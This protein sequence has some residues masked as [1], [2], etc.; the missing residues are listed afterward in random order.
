MQASLDLAATGYAVVLADTAPAIGG[1]MSRLDKTFP[2]NDCAMCIMS[3]K[4]V[5]TGR[6]LDIDIVPGAD[7][8]SLEG[9]PGRFKAALKVRARYVDLEKCTACGDC[10]AACPVELP[11]PFD[12]GLGPRRAAY[13][14]YPQAVPNAYAIDK[15]GTSPCRLAC[16]SGVNVQG[17]VALTR[18]GK[19]R[20][21]WELV[22]EAL[23]FPI[24][25]GTV[26]HRPCER[27][28]QR[29]ELDEPL[30]VARIKRFLGQ[31]MLEHPDVENEALAK[32][33]VLPADEPAQVAIVGSGPA[34]L[35][36]AYHLARA[37]IKAVVFEAL[38]VP[39]GMMRVGI[40]SYRLPRDLL[41]HEIELI[42]QLGVEIHCNQALGRDFTLA[43]LFKQGFRAV[44]LAVGAHIPQ[45][46]D[47]PGEDLPGVFHGVEFL[48]GV[49]LDDPPVLGE[50]VLVVGGGNTAVDTAR[51][52]IRLGARNVRLLYRRTAGEMT[53]Q[54]EE[55]DEA[56][57]EGVEIHF[58]VSPVEV[59]AGPDGRAAGL[60]CI[61]N[62]LGEPDAS[63]RRRPVPI[64]GSEFD[65]SASSVVF[66]TSQRPGTAGFGNEGI[67]LKLGRGG[68]IAADPLTLATSREGVFAAGDA[69]TGPA[70]L[71]DAAGAGRRAAESI[72][73]WLLGED[74]AAGRTLVQQPEDIP[75]LPVELAGRP[76][77]RRPRE[78]KL[79]PETRR[80]TFAEVLK[81]LDA[82]AA[83][84]EA[85][86]CL[87]CGGCSECLQCVAACLPKCIDHSQQDE[88]RTVE[89]GAV[90]LAAGAVPANAALRPEFGYGVHPN[91][92][93]SIEFER[94][95]SASGPLAGE[96]L[97]PSDGAHPKRIAFIQCVGSREA[98][99][100][101]STPQER[102]AALAHPGGGF[103]AP[104]AASCGEEYCSS[105][106][107]MY[108]AKEAVIAQEHVPGLQA[109]VFYM[110]LRTYGKEFERYV[111]RA[112][113]ENGVRYIRSMVSSVRELPQTRSLC[114]RYR[115]PGGPVAEE[116]FDLVV[117]AVGLRPPVQAQETA[118][119]IAVELNEHGY[120]RTGE[121]DP[122]ATSRPG[123]Y[124]CGAFREPK[125]I[126]ETVTDGSAAAAAAS[127]LLASAR[128]SL[129]RKR[130]FPPERDVRR[131]FP[132]VGVIVCKCGRNIGSVIDSDAVAAWAASLPGVVWAESTLYTC[133]QDSIARIKEA[134]VEHGLNRVVVASCTP[135]THESLFRETIR[136]A[137]LNPALFEMAN[138]REQ[139]SWVHR[140][141]PLEATAKA[142]DL[143]A[144][145]VAK[146]RLLEPV[147]SAFFDINHRALVVGG[148]ASGMTATVSL[149]GQ[150]FEVYLI[151]RESELGGNLRRIHA[152]LEGGD[153]AAFLT[154]L[155]E[156]V[157]ANP[158]I[159]V[160]TRARVTASTGYVGNYKTSVVSETAA[161]PVEQ[162]L[163]HGVVVVATGALPGRPSPGYLYGE[164][165]RV[166]TQME[167]DEALAR[168][169][170]GEERFTARTVAMIQCAGSREPDH[171]Y[172]SRVCCSEAVRNAL[173][174][175]Q[176]NPEARVYVFNRDIRTYGFK[177]TYYGKAREAGVIFVRYE[178]ESKPQVMVAP[179]GELVLH[180]G[181]PD[182]GDARIVLHPDLVALAPPI[183]PDVDP[184]LAQAFK[185]PLTAD[186]F[187]LEA[188]MKLRPVD[189]ATDGAFLCGLAHG[190]KLLSESLAQAEAASVR[191]AGVLSQEQ[192]ESRGNVA[193]VNERLCRGCGVCV[194]LCAYGARVLDE[195]KGIA[196]VL[197]VLCQGCGACVAGCPSGA[198]DQEGFSKRQIAA[199]LEAVLGYEAL[200]AS[201]PKPGGTLAGAAADREVAGQ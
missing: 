42:A 169:E 145:A 149:A 133:S 75:R 36:C 193:R 49:S 83:Q 31:E 70:M 137:G 108:T 96:L 129:T 162:E 79:D 25:C 33:T 29:A 168:A 81:P 201:S 44:M 88:I 15:L 141:R 87:S 173:K 200:D 112:Q 102:E 134:V 67:E 123:V 60:R 194:D 2:T 151:E 161:G 113:Q 130:E 167:L 95:L 179:D 124:A 93:S 163:E 51:T 181:D 26:C 164:H 189:F 46:A 120:V 16:P 101:E 48:R 77:G 106:C 64:K 35:A 172:C 85:G 110:D 150:G 73:R 89:V 24:V 140:D 7:L 11:N 188:H 174:I 114:I 139:S 183:V 184:A 80:S 126:P 160:L 116:Q 54:P 148:G 27:A 78:H 69:V 186:G 84:A 66:A 91:V 156:K 39:G 182:L 128:A 17:F 97:R 147:Q 38:P 157:G 99:G 165:P 10:A 107:C 195:E 187:F 58:L 122:T 127:R 41:A 55:I 8:V 176:L 76:P 92:V 61:R 12:V 4:L 171:P 197:Q 47:V 121:F 19:P 40:P 3:P 52:A 13:K 53:A 155:I 5:D 166:V 177:E 94:M 62:E 118:R 198:C 135:R 153:P 23:P 158:L 37:G 185:L 125:D 14:L 178:P 98:S 72:R 131:E 32:L 146:A 152:T 68:T 20:E 170:R 65:L 30:S 111:E 6:H 132:R 18:V 103:F 109:T 192:L 175:K 90:I 82:A 45:R 86:R 199:M 21:A 119:R 50:T 34:G 191:A 115:L 180:A 136:E 105:V 71:I 143:V 63:G 43:G 190:P 56:R 59:L 9:K 138:I 196:K 154:G 28:C 159:H 74:L 144:A 22:R 117:L 57:E 104:P 1:V 142:A 100:R